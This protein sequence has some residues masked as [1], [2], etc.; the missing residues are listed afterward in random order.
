MRS[1]SIK[2]IHHRDSAS[3]KIIHVP[4]DYR[5][6]MHHG[7]SGNQAVRG[8]QSLW[9]VQSAPAIRNFR[10][11]GQ[12]RVCVIHTKPIQPLLDEL[13]PADV[14]SSQQFDPV[15]DLSQ[16]HDTEEMPNVQVRLCPRQHLG[17]ALRT[18]SQ[19]RDDVCVQK[20][21]HAK[22]TW[23]C[24]P[25]SLDRTGRKS[26]GHGTP[27]LSRNSTRLCLLAPAAMACGSYC[28]ALARMLRC[29]SS[30]ETPCSMAWLR[31]LSTSSSSTFSISN[32]DMFKT[33]SAVNTS[34]PR[35]RTQE[36]SQC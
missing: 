33:A 10:R 22:F 20:E 15:S 11:H 35:I 4:R 18:L 6:L 32:F 19:L 29:S 13:G 14:L 25:V 31:S 21:T 9:N 24:S 23:R 12:D 2:R 17:V 28:K 5:K 30:T 34:Q 26:S 36:A 8:R 16:S 3:Q 7:S 1:D 27:P